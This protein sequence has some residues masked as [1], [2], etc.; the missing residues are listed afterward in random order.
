M[1]KYSFF[2]RMAAA[3]FAAVAL[4][5]TAA[6]S[7]V[8]LLS[9]SGTWFRSASG[10]AG[11]PAGNGTLNNGRI[12]IRPTNQNA[13][14]IRYIAPAGQSRALKVGEQIEL[15]FTYSIDTPLSRSQGL[16]IGLFNS[17]GSPRGA[18][19]YKSADA[20]DYTGYFVATSPR[21]GADAATDLFVRTPRAENPV[22]LIAG[23]PGSLPGPRA[24]SRGYVLKSG[25]TYRALLRIAYI[26]EDSVRVSYTFNADSAEHALVSWTDRAGGTTA[27][28]TVALNFGKTSSDDTTTLTV[29]GLSYEITPVSH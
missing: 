9:S 19:N 2:S 23:G 18:G 10:F 16:R 7:P 5:A 6:A 3:A 8:N 22:S 4:A 1:K 13:E 24:Q 20:K 27:F 28:D 25:T 14:M 21:S 26:S 11:A 17:N 12:V 29:S 15:S